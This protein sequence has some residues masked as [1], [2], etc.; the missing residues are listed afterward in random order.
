MLSAHL[1]IWTSRV[2]GAQQ[3][4]EATGYHIGQRRSKGLMVEVCRYQLREPSAVHKH[5]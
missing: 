1:T 4:S 3:P 2:T 5:K